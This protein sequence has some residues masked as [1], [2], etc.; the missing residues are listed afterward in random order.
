MNHEPLRVRHLGGDVTRDAR[1]IAVV[2]RRQTFDHQYAVVLVH[3]GDGHPLGRSHGPTVLQPGYR[4]GQI[5]PGHRAREGSALAE[6]ELL[7]CREGAN[8]GRDWNAQNKQRKTND[9][10]MMFVV[11][12]S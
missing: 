12:N 6:M 8:F 3:A 11:I 5:A 2:I 9:S 4:Q 7:V 10:L 1:V